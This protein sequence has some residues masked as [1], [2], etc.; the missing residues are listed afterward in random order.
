[1][2]Y[3]SYDALNKLNHMGGNPLGSSHMGGMALDHFNINGL[4][5]GNLSSLANNMNMSGIAN[6]MND[7]N[8]L[9]S[10]NHV[11]GRR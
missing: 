2:D 1:M 3:N 8:R 9:S 10:G 11:S 4:G 7:M 6:G 5:L